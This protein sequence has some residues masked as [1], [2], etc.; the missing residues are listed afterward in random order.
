MQNYGRSHKIWEIWQPYSL[1]PLFAPGPGVKFPRYTTV[2]IDINLRNFVADFNNYI[3]IIF[4]WVLIIYMLYFKTMMKVEIPETM[5][6]LC[7]LQNDNEIKYNNNIIIIIIIMNFYS[8]VSNTR[9]HSMG[10]KIRR[11][12]IKIRF[13]NSNNNNNNNSV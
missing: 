4:K 9:C 11:A 10:H 3:I 2:A 5:W 1:R 6:T 8:P 13:H 12:R 7:V